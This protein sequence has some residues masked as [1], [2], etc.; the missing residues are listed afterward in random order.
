MTNLSIFRREKMLVAVLLSVL[1][2]SACGPGEKEAVGGKGAAATSL[3][4]TIK[5]SGAWA[6][7]P[8][9]VRWAEEFRKVHPGVRI[10]VSAGGAGKGIADT[11]AGLVDIGM[12][13]REI[14]QEEMRQGV[15]V[16]PVTKDAVV[17]TMN[18]GNPMAADILKRGV[19]KQALVDLWIGGQP[20]TWGSIADRRAGD[21]V[22]VYTRSD[23]CGAA[24][25]WAAYLGNRKQEDLKGVAVYG[26]PGLTE[27][28]RKDVRG[29]GY[30]N[31]NYA[32]AGGTGMPVDGISVI[33]IDINGNGRIDPEE[34]IGSKRKAIGAIR[35]GVYP[36]PPARNLY[37]VVK[38]SFG[39]PAREFI[40]WILTDGQQFVD[41][42]G[43]IGLA[44]QQIRDA[45]SRT[46]P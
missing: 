43:Y 14:K 9:M 29:I 17:P 1:A 13:S 40:R 44:E 42:A 11:I 21:S 8:M 36:S 23:A 31:L 20:S 24:E 18:A 33:S 25:T 46:G 6:L 39:G 15:A 22:R 19:T 30:N 16:V 28:V 12:V 41:E 26:D 37:L 45:L 32:F 7:Y 4:G 35:S 5:V 10:D 3:T 2:L 38:G 34:D 27:A